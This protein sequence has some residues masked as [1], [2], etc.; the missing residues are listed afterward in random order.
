MDANNAD[1]KENLAE[2]RGSGIS[3]PSNADESR[4]S[5]HKD[6][7]YDDMKRNSSGL[8]EDVYVDR[9]QQQPQY[10]AAIFK[11]VRNLQILFQRMGMYTEEMLKSLQE[12]SKARKMGGGTRGDA[13]F[14]SDARGKT[15][16]QLSG[17]Q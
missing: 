6:T 2:R 8:A 15:D 14:G 3:S 10:L 11:D 17:N 12:S 13:D 7:D 16:H 5:H 1:K 9:N 4:L